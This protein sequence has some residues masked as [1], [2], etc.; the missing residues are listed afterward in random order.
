MENLAGGG[1]GGLEHSV[2]PRVFYE[3]HLVVIIWHLGVHD[4]RVS[5]WRCEAQCVKESKGPAC[6]PACVWGATCH[7]SFH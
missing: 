2:V 7:R 3:S 6:R 1:Q 5:V 4:G